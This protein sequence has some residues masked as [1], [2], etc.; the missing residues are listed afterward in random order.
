MLRVT[1]VILT[2]LLAHC[3]CLSC[4]TSAP[5]VALQ[6]L[7][8]GCFGEEN[9]RSPE[10]YAALHRYCQK[11][12]LNSGAMVGMGREVL[13]NQIG[14][15]CVAAQWVGDVPVS[16]LHLYNAGC[17]IEASQSRDCLAAAHR[18][19]NDKLEADAGGIS[20]EVGTGTLLVT[21]FKA[22]RREHVITSVL[23]DEGTNC[24]FPDSDSTDCFSAASKWCRRFGHDGGITQEVNEDG[25]TVACYDAMYS[26][27]AFFRALSDYY[28]AQV[29]LGEICSFE[30]NTRRAQIVERTPQ[31]LK[32]VTYDNEDSVV[33]LQSNFDVTK[34]LT[35]EN[36][37]QHEHSL[38]I[39]PEV[40]IKTNVPY[41]ENWDVK[42][43]A[44]PTTTLFLTQVNTE[45]VSY[46]FSSP[47]TVPAGTRL[48]KKAVVTVAEMDVEWSA[49][50]ITGLGALKTIG[51]N[52]KGFSTYDFKVE[53][54]ARA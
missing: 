38:I 26:G 52:W 54:D 41:V 7:H 35:L 25:M 17:Q 47:V 21:C 16:D 39:G 44:F 48:V 14:V 45:T 49:E 22:A 2:A 27:N 29:S 46:T 9:A 23:N 32:Q 33:Q 53:Q 15:S 4:T 12:E 43:S 19:C 18:F 13:G 30:F 34:E 51:G 1:L 8:E 50:V 28:N 42:T 6:Q 11:V 10:C 3:S 24:S 37:F 36:H 20:Q 5:E 31:I 40:T